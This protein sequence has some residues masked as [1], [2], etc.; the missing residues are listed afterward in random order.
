MKKILLLIG[1]ILV[2]FG[3][4]FLQKQT[5]PNTNQS[6][7]ISPTPDITNATKTIERFSNGNA[8]NIQFTGEYDDPIWGGVVQTF[9]DS[10]GTDYRVDKMANQ[11][12]FFLTEDGKS[13]IGSSTTLVSSTQAEKIGTLFAEKN[14][15][16]YENFT[17]TAEY[18][19]SQDTAPKMDG[20]YYLNWTGQK[21]GTTKDTKYTYNGN[22]VTPPTFHSIV[23]LDKFGNVISFQNEYITEELGR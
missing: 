21:P 16:D 4:L 5:R 23:V 2:F 7:I 3:F 10:N 14:M 11:V 8:T 17:K 20:R 12:V 19:F 6:I 9:K 18:S 13:K 15:I 1:F 22:S